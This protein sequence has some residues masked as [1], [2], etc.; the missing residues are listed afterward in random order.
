MPAV[1]QIPEFFPTEFGTNWDHLVQQK[2]SKLKDYVMV[3]SVKG[4]EKAYN[5]V[6]SVEMSRVLVRAGDTTITDTP[7]AKRW[8]RPFPHEK[9]DLLDQWD[10]EYLGEIAL[11]QSEI[12]QAHAAA[13]ARTC[14]RL[15][16]EAAV[17]TAYTGETGT[18]ATVLPS[19]Q[20]VAV[21]Y[22][23]SGSTANSGLTVAKLRA[24]KY[25]LDDNEVDD[26][27]PRIIAVSAKQLQD[28]LRTTEVT[29]ADY[30]TVKALVA[31]QV[32]S[33][34]GFK[35]RRVSKSFFEYASGTGIRKIV[36]YAK[37][38]LRLT[39][40]G[41][42]SYVDIRAD[43]SHALQLRTVASIGAARMEEAKVVEIACD[44]VL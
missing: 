11:P 31:G 40:S 3:D 34:L 14:D 23:E 26:E 12:L 36:A 20:K 22:V 43:K 8:L 1:T 5:Q 39:D 21:D 24:A 37:S 29:S 33:F 19:A 25:I 28:L 2:L 42:R 4:K 10:A 13:Y 44:E 16:I 32:D 6:G 15:I 30:N 35:F 9:G 17:G 41:R 27:D 38:G 7:L 18:T